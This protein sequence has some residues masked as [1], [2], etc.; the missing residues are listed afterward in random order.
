[1]GS[2]LEALSRNGEWLVRIED[3]DPPR[4]VTGAA[5]TILYTLERFGFE[6]HGE[7][8]FQSS[9]YPAYQATLDE[10]RKRDLV[11]DCTCSRSQIQAT[12]RR[13]PEGII[14][15]GTCRGG[16]KA[17]SAVRSQ[18][19]IR[20]KTDQRTIVFR[21]TLH[22]EI[23]QNL[24]SELGDFILK[25]ADRIYAYQLAVVVDDAFQGITHIVRGADLLS[26]TPR[27]IY[28]QQLLDLPTPHYLH[29][30]LALDREGKKL[31][32]QAGSIAVDPANPLPA[33]QEAFRF[34]GQ[35]PPG[36]AVSNVE[37]FWLWA[38]QHWTVSRIGRA[39]RRVAD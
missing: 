5:E 22:G 7:V 11:Y 1:M 21:D 20:V 33:L 14:Y 28:L 30:P 8:L 9:R 25:R 18:R 16:L 36:Q 39:A 13:G 27:Q 19:A 32:K 37:E 31:S 23:S 6:W 12:G 3:I 15:P 29:L 24:Y 35:V 17:A 2:Y 4:E 38:R 26:S 34:L 10:L